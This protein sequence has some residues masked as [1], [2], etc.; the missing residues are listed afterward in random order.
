MIIL[1]W[2]SWIYHTAV[3]H[4]T[5]REPGIMGL[6]I[7]LKTCWQIPR[8]EDDHNVCKAKLLF[9]LCISQCLLCLLWCVLL[10]RL[11]TS[12]VMGR[13]QVLIHV[14]IVFTFCVRH[15]S[16]CHTFRMH[17]SCT[18]MDGNIKYRKALVC[19]SRVLYNGASLAKTPQQ[20]RMVFM[21]LQICTFSV[22]A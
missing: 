15:S 5:T 13:Q 16:D 19:E 11:L 14:E 9:W 12:P 1:Q 2:I 21:V 18:G 3:R 7:S 22:A 17:A 6:E 20:R 8:K 10:D 4:V